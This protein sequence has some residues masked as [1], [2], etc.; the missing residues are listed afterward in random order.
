MR[1]QTKKTEIAYA[2]NWGPK[3]AGMKRGAWNRIV[4]TVA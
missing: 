1:N 4:D 2:S 3:V